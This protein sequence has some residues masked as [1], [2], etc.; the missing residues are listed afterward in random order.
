MSYCLV[1]GIVKWGVEGGGTGYNVSYN[2]ITHMID[3]PMI[4]A[5]YIML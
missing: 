3:P 2:I 1:T 4:V 5:Y